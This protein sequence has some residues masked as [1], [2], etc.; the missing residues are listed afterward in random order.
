MVLKIIIK[1]AAPGIKII[2][3][4]AYVS[5]DDKEKAFE[6]GCDDFVGKPLS[7]EQLLAVIKKHLN[8]NN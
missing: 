2:A 6:A 7:R 1:S 8:S 4:T 5:N 3:Q